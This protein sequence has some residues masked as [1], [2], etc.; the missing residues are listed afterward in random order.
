MDSQEGGAAPRAAVSVAEDL[1]A[2]RGRVRG[3]VVEEEG[4]NPEAECVGDAKGVPKQEAGGKRRAKAE[5]KSKAKA[6]AKAK[7]KT[8]QKGGV[9]KRPAKKTP[10][11]EHGECE[12]IGS[13]AAR[14]G[15]AQEA[16]CWRLL[17]VPVPPYV[18]CVVLGEERVRGLRSGAS[19]HG[20]Y[21]A[22]LGTQGSA[23]TYMCGRKNAR[24]VDGWYC[25]LARSGIWAGA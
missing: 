19:K 16:L 11:R 10:P 17:H 21:A 3:M 25:I 22:P 12:A 7:T 6:K 9:L 24:R 2:L 15:G 23:S 20:A 8:V 4:E 5:A 18:H 14:S 13:A 1:E